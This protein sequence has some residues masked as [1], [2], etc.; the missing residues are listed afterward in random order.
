MDTIYAAH[1]GIR[2]LVLLLGVCALGYFAVGWGTNRGFGRAARILGAAYVGTLHLQ[3]V[4]GILLIVRGV[5]YPALNGH[6]A[7]MLAAA[8][9]ATVM[10]RRGRGAPE[11]GHAHAISLGGVLLSL[12][13]IVGGI[14]SIGRG[15]FGHKPL[16]S[17]P[18]TDRPS[19]DRLPTR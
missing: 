6:L 4:L 8:A 5:Y 3:V 17:P 1:S 19:V 15:V 13:L 14:L 9:A 10:I 11:G 2:Y 12:L 18:S 16:N 7:L